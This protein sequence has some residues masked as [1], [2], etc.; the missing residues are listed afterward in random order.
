MTTHPHLL[1][2]TDKIDGLRSVAEVRTSLA[3][4][5]PGRLWATLLARAEQD[6]AIPPYIP[7]SSIPDRAAEQSETGNR[8]YRIVNAAANRIQRAALVNLLTGA[9]RFADEA[10]RQ[11]D[12]LY[13]EKRW[14]DWRDLAHLSNPADLRTGQFMRAIGLAYDWLYPSLTDDER[15]W[16]VEGL[17]RRGIRPFF[18]SLDKNAFWARRDTLPNNW[19]TCIVGGAG[20]AGMA[21]REDHP[22]SRQLVDLSVEK[23]IDYLNVLGPEGESNESIGYAGAMHFP[24]QF[25]N[26]HRYHVGGGDSKLFDQRFRKFCDWYMYFFLPPGVNA[27]F[28]D[29][30]LN[31]PPQASM[32]AIM[33]AATRDPVY[34][35]FYEQ[36]AAPTARADV[37]EALLSY[38]PSVPA[39]PPD[40]RRPLGRGFRA[41]SACWSS[42][43]S[44]H[45]RSAACAV[46]GK[47]GHGSEGHGHH[48]AGSVCIDAY[49]R[50]LIS[51]P[52]SLNYPKDF[53]GPNRYK[54]YNAAAWGH[55]VPV[56]GGREMRAGKEHAAT[57]VDMRFDHRLGAAWLADTTAMYEGVSLVRRGVIHLLPGVVAVLDVC[58][59]LQA[60]DVSIRWHTFDRAEPDAAGAFVV[61]NNGARLVARMVCLNA[62]RPAFARGE[63]E[64]VEPFN[65]DRLGYPLEQKRESF[66][67]ARLLS[68]HVRLLSVFRTCCPG[69]SPA[70]WESIEDGW[71][72]ISATG[73]VRVES[74]GARVS[75]QSAGKTISIDA[76]DGRVAMDGSDMRPE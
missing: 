76:V 74:D 21:M 22:L 28:G 66:V 49:A 48:D 68:Q 65:L 60:E 11:I 25:F 42:R 75:A 2:T 70:E 15:R 24:I 35:W 29:S 54:Y 17:D 72:M 20:I 13:N 1:L 50:R 43:T 40:G 16:I 10:L 73:M 45:P 46:Y 34:Q 59:L 38:D 44:W 4:G 6:I 32:F 71:M 58:D 26:V 14:P 39:E 53:F 8:D 63:H 5:M 69:E 31:A 51:D 19:M 3:Q 36:H 27:A 30:H 7:S 47:G 9:R 52:G 55:N 37:C 23:F 67:E 64:Y 12:C 57:I 56:F 41:H 33:A 62:D 18:E 61:E